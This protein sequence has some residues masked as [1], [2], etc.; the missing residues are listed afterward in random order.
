MSVDI[1][2]ICHGFCAD[3]T[4]KISHTVE[5]VEDGEILKC[6]ECGWSAPK[7]FVSP[8]QNH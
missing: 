4:N 3:G 6:P 7:D 2:K 1:N 5:L 8:Y